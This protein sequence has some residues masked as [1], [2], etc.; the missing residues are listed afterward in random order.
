MDNMTTEELLKA[1]NDG[2]KIR[3]KEWGSVYFIERY[4]DIECIDERGQVEILSDYKS[5]EYSPEEWEIITPKIIS[6]I[7]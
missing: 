4:S 6:W 5:I 1:Y 7:I 3:K 2:L